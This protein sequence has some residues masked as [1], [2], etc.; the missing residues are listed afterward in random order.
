[1]Y[2]STSQQSPLPSLPGQGDE[3]ISYDEFV[4]NIQRAAA[5]RRQREAREARLYGY[6]QDVPQSELPAALQVELDALAAQMRRNEPVSVRSVRQTNANK[7]RLSAL[8]RGWR[9]G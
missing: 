6:A 5:R 3:T 4:L 9:G 7:A 2:Q 1:M 8:I